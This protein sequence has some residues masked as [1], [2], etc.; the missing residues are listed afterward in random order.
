MN[1]PVRM[2]DPIALHD[3]ESAS[4]AALLHHKYIAQRLRDRRA[5][6][7]SG[8][9]STYAMEIPPA[10]S[11]IKN[12][13]SS[14]VVYEHPTEDRRGWIPRA[15]IITIAPSEAR[16]TGI[17]NL[18]SIAVYCLGMYHPT[19]VP[20]VWQVT[21]C[22]PSLRWPHA[23]G[24]SFDHDNHGSYQISYDHVG[25]MERIPKMANKH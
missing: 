13:H 14:T 5:F 11:C 7:G 6:Q 3:R 16:V 24:R 20:A 21:I 25:R 1:G 22:L 2:R 19:H 8:S 12:F 17:K 23:S 4:I 9:S 18:G 15:A 10:S